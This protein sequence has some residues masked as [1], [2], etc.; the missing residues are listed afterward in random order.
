[1]HHKGSGDMYA[2]GGAFIH[3]L[4]SVVDNDTLWF[5]LFKSMTNHFKHQTVD[6]EKF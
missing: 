2:K 4:R 1:M 3:T 5:D 6:G